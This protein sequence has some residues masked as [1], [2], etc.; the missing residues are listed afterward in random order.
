MKTTMFEI[1]V[2]SNLPNLRRDIFNMLP[3]GS[4]MFDIT[5]EVIKLRRVID[6]L[7]DEGESRVL[8]GMD[9]KTDE[10]I[11]QVQ[12]HNESLVEVS[13]ALNDVGYRK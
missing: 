13:R 10:Y 6:A 2:S 3:P 12:I 1:A 9:Q 4:A 11:R 7:L 5:E 8:P